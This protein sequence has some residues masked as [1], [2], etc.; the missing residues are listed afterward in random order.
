MKNITLSL[1]LILFCTIHG[2]TSWLQTT[3]RSRQRREQPTLPANTTTV[4]TKHDDIAHFTCT[5]RVQAAITWK[6][7]TTDLTNNDV[8]VA[9]LSVKNGATWE[10]HLFI[11]VTDD[12]LRGKYTCMSSD[13]PDVVLQAFIIENDP[14]REGMLMP[15]DYWAIILSLVI[16]FILAV[17]L[18]FFLWRG[19]RRIKKA[20][21][22]TKAQ[23]SRSNHDGAQENL[24]VEEEIV[25]I[26]VNDIKEKQEQ[27]KKV[28]NIVVEN[29]NN[30]TP[31]EIKDGTRSYSPSEN[32]TEVVIEPAPGK[33]SSTQ[34]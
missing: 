33:E 24:A 17:S 7:E 25:D 20:R 30:N 11:A 16:S 1:I 4:S 15:E 9:M 2:S 26:G 23:R 22:E 34:F 8:G 32:K 19:N 6:R 31:G 12:D 28:K 29:G 10:S 3:E 5:S 14:A 27:K 21:E 18:A 13:K